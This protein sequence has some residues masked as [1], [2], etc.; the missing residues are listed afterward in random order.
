MKNNRLS[1]VNFYPHLNFASAGKKDKF[2]CEI[3]CIYHTE[4]IVI[5]KCYYGETQKQAN[6]KAQA[7]ATKFHNYIAYKAMIDG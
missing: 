4:N 5:W 3:E 1:T 2:C 6:A 7:Q